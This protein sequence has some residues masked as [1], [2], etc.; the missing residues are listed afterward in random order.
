MAES[1]GLDLI[2]LAD[3]IAKKYRN[4]KSNAQ[5]RKYWI[6]LSLVFIFAIGLYIRVQSLTP[7]SDC[8][9]G[10]VCLQA[11]DP[12]Y[13]YRTSLDMM[14]N[15]F[16]LV[17]DTLRYYPTGMDPHIVP[18]VV[19]YLP[20]VMYKLLSLIVPSLTYLQWAKLYPAV[21]GAL[22][23]VVMYLLGKEL[24][25]RKVG[26]LAGFLLAVNTSTL[27][28]TA[29]GFI[30]KEPAAIVFILLAFYFFA[31]ALNKNSTL[32]AVNA[33][34]SLLMMNFAWGGGNIVFILIALFTGI[35]VFFNLHPKSL[36]K[37][38]PIM[39]SIPLFVPVLVGV[40][41]NL[42][43]SMSYALLCLGVMALVFVRY[44]IEEDRYIDEK[45]MKYAV[46]LLCAAGLVLAFIG[47]FFSKTL[48]SLFSAVSGLLNWSE[49]VIGSTVA[50]NNPATWATIKTQIGSTYAQN[51][52]PQL[53][54]IIPFLSLWIFMLIGI[55]FLSYKLYKTKEWKYMFGLVWVVAS[56]YASF[57]RTRII[58]LLGPPAALAAA[59]GIYYMIRLFNRAEFINNFKKYE[60]AG[61]RVNILK[62]I[63]AIFII[64][65]LV[66][67][68]SSGLAF[69]KA[70]GPSL[71]KNWQGACEYLKT[72]TP[73]D[74]VIL[75]WWDYGYWFETA[76]E[77]ASV[78]D[79]GNDFADEINPILANG[80]IS[81]NISDLKNVI[82]YFPAD[83][84]VVDYT[85]IGKFSAM[86]KIGHYGEKVNSF[87]SL[88][89][90]NSVPKDNIT[91][92]AYQLGTNSIYV[93]VDS[94]G[95]I[96]GNINFVTPQGT[97]YIKGLCTENGF[98]DLN[99]PEPTFDACLVFS[100]FG[101]Y[102]PYPEKE[103]GLSNFAKLYLFDGAGVPFLEKVYDNTEIK[104]FKVIDSTE[105]VQEFEDMI[106]INET[107]TEEENNSTNGAYN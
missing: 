10:M 31:H 63:P 76:G 60:I 19:F 61:F 75:S 22:M 95:G 78:A 9:E 56:I 26:L 57:A 38:Y 17:F 105:T 30:E 79:G 45:S 13:I 47:S 69:S 8:I 36:Y 64:L 28:R 97:A 88:N 42:T 65:L 52:V 71:N 1:S 53:K 84:V 96:A 14:N 107:Q 74:A 23:G 85:L 72:E 34:L 20:A 80:F 81:D 32:S 35:I 99:S 91:I 3:N 59:Y 25:N 12:F 70:I 6:T 106:L 104:I 49:G 55:F 92:M 5:F 82:E 44:F 67:N 87:I 77:R 2:A 46:P 43:Y 68:F 33:G 86:S 16:H 24:F 18:P 103:A 41:A 54:P 90:V 4:I 37:A 66:V 73:Q 21:M 50:E 15:N 39:I 100:K 29:A 51:L 7:L 48:A 101:V 89:F 40:K 11:L 98:V 58:F 62:I 102:M 27:Y 93:P 83:Y 94:N